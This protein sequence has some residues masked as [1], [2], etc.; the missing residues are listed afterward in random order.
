[1]AQYIVNNNSV[2]NLLGWIKSDE[3]AIPEIQRP[4]VWDS[5]KV[6][7]LID[8]LYNGFPVG[9]IITWKNPDVKLKDG[10]ISLGKKVLIDGQ[11]R[12]TALTAAISGQM[13]INENYKKIR[14]KISFNPI[15]EKFEVCNPALEKD[16]QWI[17]DI[18][19]IFKPTFDSYQF[20]SEYAS[21]N[22][23]LGNKINQ[24][25]QKLL[26][27]RTNS[28]GVI[29][30]SP[31]LDIETVTEIFIRI[32]SKGVV[33]SQADFAMSKISSNDEFGGRIIRKTIDYFCHL[34]KR[35]MDIEQIVENDKEFCSLEAF[36]KIK[37]IVKETDDIYVP[38]YSDVLRVAFTSKFNRGKLADL[39]SLLSGRDFESRKYLEDI[40]RD[41]FI[42]LYEGVLDFVNQTNY[43]RYLMIV[44]SVGIIDKSLIRSQ[45]VMN[46]GYILYL[47]LKNKGINSNIIEKS[48]RKWLILSI[49]TGRYSGSPESAFDYDIKRFNSYDNPLEYIEN[50]EEG[51]LSDAYWNNI[52]VTRLDTSVASSPYFNLYLMAQ[53]KDGDK[54]FLSANIKV[55]DLIEER[56][57]VHHLFPKKYL[58]S[59]GYNLRGVYNQ[60]ANYVYTQSEINIKIKD[61]SPR[62]YMIQIINEMESGTSSVCNLTDMKAL[63]DNF[64]QNC[65][66]IEFITYTVDNYEQFLSQRR[67]LMAKKIEKFY[68]SL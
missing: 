12:I 56:G 26:S 13:V 36:Y 16:I 24:T 42:K 10:R 58:Q 60:I 9:Y 50:E 67:I 11:Q 51:N 44:K 49:L 62:D 39:V 52:L 4:F 21:L 41:S 46:F 35:P 54:G 15:T 64:A 23:V 20:V 29:D 63:E 7:D 65:I 38:T 30:L 43:Q 66:P 8:S 25:I 33:L 34:K 6:R 5:S 14:I 17:P 40:S 53:I 22:N 68:K 18:S 61:K 55:L 2:E 47:V 59:N 37:W 3:I 31:E 57:D 1:M 48:V 28:I 19:V 45:N 27:I 32:N